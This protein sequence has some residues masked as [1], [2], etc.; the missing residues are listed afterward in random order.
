MF[1]SKGF[2]SPLKLQNTLQQNNQDGCYTNVYKTCNLWLTT[3]GTLI[4]SKIYS[5]MQI[6]KLDKSW[7]QDC[8]QMLKVLVWL[9]PRQLDFCVFF[10][11]LYMSQIQEYLILSSVSDL[12]KK[13]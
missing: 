1:Q 10:S 8:N 4:R 5:T 13:G 6:S 2:S 9:L 11:Y 7:A 3:D 12:E